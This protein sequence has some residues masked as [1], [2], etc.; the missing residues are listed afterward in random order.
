MGSVMFYYVVRV[1]KGQRNG[2][3]CGDGWERAA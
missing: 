1:E 2:I 3:L